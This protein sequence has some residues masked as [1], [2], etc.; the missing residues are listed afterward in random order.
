MRIVTWNCK[1]AFH[2]KHQFV[3]ALRADILVVPECEQQKEGATWFGPDA[4]N[5][6]LWFGDSPRKGLAAFSFGEYKL[7]IHPNYDASYKWIVPIVVSGPK[8]FLLFA[9]W[10]LPKGQYRGRYVR[11]LLEALTTYESLFEDLPV[12]WVGDYNSNYIFDE[13]TRRYKFKDY[14]SLLAKRGM[15][16]VYHSVTGAEHGAEPDPTFWLYHRENRPYHI[17]YVFA[18]DEFHTGRI[19]VAIGSHAEW[20]ARSDHAP[21][22]C[23]FHENNGD[24]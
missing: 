19:S 8:T 21:L 7:S 1:G 18:Q 17:D 9:V 12:V 3:A 13:P 4:V 16:S 6:S 2:R 23:D 14:V 5:T 15:N 11:P 20:S 24:A 22:V 10:T